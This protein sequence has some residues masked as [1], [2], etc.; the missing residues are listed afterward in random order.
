MDEEEVRRAPKSAIWGHPRPLANSKAE[1]RSHAGLC[2]LSLDMKCSSDGASGYHT[3]INHPWRPRAIGG[4]GR[5]LGL[6]PLTQVSQG[7]GQSKGL[8]V[9][10]VHCRLNASVL[11]GPHRSPITPSIGYLCNYDMSISV[12]GMQ[13]CNV[14]RVSTG[15]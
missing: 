5:I 10:E 11:S 9:E 8:T 1:S 13:G 14:F 12:A 2:S 15:F 6:L 7:S 3:P 4:R